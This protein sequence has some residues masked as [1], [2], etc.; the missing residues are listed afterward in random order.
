MHAI[1]LTGNNYGVLT[2]TE[3]E[4][5]HAVK[6]SP[7]VPG[8]FIRKSELDAGFGGD[9]R[10]VKPPAVRITADVSAIDVL[11]NWAG[12]QRESDAT[13]PYLHQ[14]RAC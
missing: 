9:G 2:E 13:V 4:G 10:Q 14:L 12:W 8:L 1:T 7:T 11:L 6:F 5:R 3:W